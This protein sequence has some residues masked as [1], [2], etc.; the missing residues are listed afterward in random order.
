MT[1]RMNPPSLRTFRIAFW[2]AN[3]IRDKKSELESFLAHHNIDVLLLCESKL[4][5]SD[6]FSVANYAT[7]RTDG[8][9][10]HGGTAV[11]LKRSFN[12]N[13]FRYRTTT[14]SKRPPSNYAS[15]APRSLK[16]RP[17][18]LGRLSHPRPSISTTSSTATIPLSPLATSTPDTSPGTAKRV[19]RANLSTTTRTVRA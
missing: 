13:R 16:S 8:P 10:R 3:G 15:A 19:P 14:D 4:V 1:P 12:S 9:H 17:R 2:N 18:T 7:I 6:R 11:I 5:S